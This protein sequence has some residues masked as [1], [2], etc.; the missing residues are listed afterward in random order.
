MPD[1]E[2]SLY[3]RLTSKKHSENKKAPTDLHEMD[4]F[5]GC[6]YA[7]T[8]ASKKIGIASAFNKQS[9]GLF[10]APDLGRFGLEHWCFKELLSHWTFAEAPDG[11][12]E[13][14]LGCCW[15]T[16]QLIH[17]FNKHYSTDF[18]HGWKVTMLCPSPTSRPPI[19]V[20]PTDIHI[21]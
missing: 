6:F 13:D 12:E 16:D 8:Q 10:P 20:P 2:R 14:A 21:I 1:G 5:I 17:Y 19:L 18:K 11:V 3:V 15:D 4:I 9:D 7:M